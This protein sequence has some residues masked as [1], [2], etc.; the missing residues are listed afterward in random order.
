M[1]YLYYKTPVVNEIEPISGPE[2]GLTQITV[3]G[4]NF[5]DLGHDSALCVF[6]QTTYT[7]ATVMSST[8]II[9]DSPSILDSRGYPKVSGKAANYILDVSIDGGL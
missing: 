9:C 6:N 7:N 5:V 4:E 2:Y 8:E 3:T 1:P